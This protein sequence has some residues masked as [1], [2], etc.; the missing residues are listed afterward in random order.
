M[1][2]DSLSGEN[3]YFTHQREQGGEGRKAREA[4]HRALSSHTALDSISLLDAP[5]ALWREGKKLTPARGF[6]KNQKE[7]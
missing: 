3:N 4:V 6:Q 2:C 1:V 7:P 5:K